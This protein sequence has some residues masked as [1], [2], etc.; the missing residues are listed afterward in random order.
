MAEQGTE[1]TSSNPNPNSFHFILLSCLF[2]L[3]LYIHTHTHTHT[4]QKVIIHPKY[5]KTE[6][7]KSGEINTAMN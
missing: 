1:F 6:E 7:I 3:Q 4:Y 2:M 5:Q